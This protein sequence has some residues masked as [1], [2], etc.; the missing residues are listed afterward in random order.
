MSIM[1]ELQPAAGP[2]LVVGGGEVATRKVRNLVEGGFAVTVIAPEVAPEIRSLPNVTIVEA[3]FEAADLPYDAPFALVFA[4]TDD[5]ALNQ[6]VGELARR[7]KILVVVADS[8]PESTFFTPATLRDGALSIGVS[9]GGASPSLARELRARIAA[10]L[11]SGWAE[12]VEAAREQ[13][14][15]QP[16]SA[17]HGP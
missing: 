16:G 10:E 17:D 7:A 2:A 4:C 9:T 14:G 6:R 5:R 1:I 8:Q 12:K 13:R 3:P 15:R 11:G